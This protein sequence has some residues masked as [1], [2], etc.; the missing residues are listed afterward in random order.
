VSTAAYVN[1][2]LGAGAVHA[3]RIDEGQDFAL[4]PGAPIRAVGKSRVLQIQPNWYQGQPAIFY[5]LLDGPQAGKVV[6]VGEQIT[7][8]VHVGQVLNAGDV[9]GHYA[10]SGTGI[11]IGYGTQSGQTLAQATTGY[12]EGKPTPAG[13]QFSS[14]L[15]QL[16]VSTSSGSSS[17]SGGGFHC[18]LPGPLS[19]AC[20]PAELGNEAREAVE[21][22]AEDVG[23]KAAEGIVNLV[24]P[25]ATKLSLYAV[26]LVGAVAM[27]VFGTSELLK[28]VGGPDL[29]GKVK[30]A[31]AR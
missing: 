24:K 16:G 14:F 4:T 9:V 21:S 10:S 25:T 30:K 22:G 13:E 31:V 6:F 19:I 27:M 8:A 11:E 20:K 2:F 26:L 15:H 7:P 5:E 29:R 3:E 1:P 18:P 23:K 12:T 28:P 17:S